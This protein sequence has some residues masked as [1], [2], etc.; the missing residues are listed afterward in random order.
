MQRVEKTGGSNAGEVVDFNG[1]P[2]ALLN[3]S[4]NSWTDLIW[5]GSSLIAEVPGSQSGSAVYRLLDHEGS[6][7]ATGNS[8]GGILATNL[9]TPFG[10]WMNSGAGDAYSWTGL[11]QDSEYSGDA[12]WYRNYSTRQARWL[13]PDPYN[14]SYDLYDPQSFNRYM[15]VNGNPLGFVDPSGQSILS[16]TCAYFP[17]MILGSAYF[18]SSDSSS[19]FRDIGIATTYASY[20]SQIQKGSCVATLEEI[21][22][23]VGKEVLGGAIGS[24]LGSSNY[25]PFIQAGMSIGCSIDYNSTACGTPEL[26]WTLGGDT[27]KVVGD[28]LDVGY[29]V[30]AFGGFSNVACDAFALYKLANQIYQLLYNVLGWG[31]PQFTGSLLPRPSDLGGLGTAPTGIPNQNLPIHKILGESGHAMLPSPGV[32]AP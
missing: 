3:P 1:H 31:S 2:L 21:G 27:G 16:D 4:G 25:Y 26:A 9:F 13:T 23:F 17:G 6:L 8:T 19:S 20:A 5:A 14:G 24:Y 29:A 28:S 22:M 32:S 12:A 10:Q 11:F 15:Y 30:C 7:A 18:S